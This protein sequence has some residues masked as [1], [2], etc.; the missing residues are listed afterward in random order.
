MGEFLESSEYIFN[1]LLQQEDMDAD[2]AEILAS[3]DYSDEQP[4]VELAEV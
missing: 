4:V 1:D 2:V 3:G